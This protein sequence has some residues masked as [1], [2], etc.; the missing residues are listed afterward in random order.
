VC[1]IGKISQEGLAKG[2]E[3]VCAVVVPSDVL[4]ERCTNSI[5]L[6]QEEVNNEIQSLAQNLA[7][8][9]RPSK[10]VLRF[11]E[12]PKTSTRK[13]KR[14]LVVDSVT[15]REEPKRFPPTNS[16]VEVHYHE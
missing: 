10:V 16:F 14:A 8:Y 2:T 7:S 3:S 12:L 1:V 9:K 6:I 13:I 15:R 4:M 11:E 5:E